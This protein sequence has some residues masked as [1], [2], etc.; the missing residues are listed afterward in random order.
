MNTSTGK[1]DR[2]TSDLRGDYF[3]EE[4]YW[5]PGHIMNA[6]DWL[7]LGGV[8]RWPKIDQHTEERNFVCTPRGIPHWGALS[9][10][11]EETAYINQKRAEAQRNELARK[12]ARA[13]TD[14]NAQRKPGRP[15]TGE[16][17]MTAAE[18]QAERRKRK[19]STK[20]AAAATLQEAADLIATLDLPEHDRS[21]L[22]NALY[23]V[24]RQLEGL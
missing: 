2:Y 7:P 20:E 13:M 3:N 4:I 9:T 24:H 1:Q 21:A 23:L 8:I 18:R 10:R 12:T 6:P 22:T 19:A 15:L 16:R 14:L 17:P 5:D 11:H